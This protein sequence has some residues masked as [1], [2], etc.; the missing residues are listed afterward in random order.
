M[1]PRCHQEA[2]QGFKQGQA[3]LQAFLAANNL[4]HRAAALEEFGVE[5][6]RDYVDSGIVSPP[7]PRARSLK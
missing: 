4:G 7:R 2:E 5:S 6:L 1:N 3:S